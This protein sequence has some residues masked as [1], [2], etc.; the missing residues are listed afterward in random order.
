MRIS[1][2]REDDVL[3]LEVSEEGIDYAEE[4]GPMIIHFTKEGRPVLIEKLD[5][6]DFLAKI[7]KASV[8]APDSKFA[9]ALI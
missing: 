2:N 7:T 5:A 1:Y 3:V 9:E 6:S 8:R 4:V